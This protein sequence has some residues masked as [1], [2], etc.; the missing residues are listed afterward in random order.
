MAALPV[1]VTGMYLRTRLRQLN[2][3]R[4]AWFPRGICDAG[5]SS[6]TSL[7]LPCPDRRTAGATP[8]MGSGASAVRDVRA[9]FHQT[10]DGPDF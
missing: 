4:V 7:R 9:S 10:Q 1:A 5:T 3:L 6:T 8:F 2:G